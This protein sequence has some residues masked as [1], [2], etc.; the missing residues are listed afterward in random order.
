MMHDFMTVQVESIIQSALGIGDVGND[1]PPPALGN[2][3]KSIP[4]TAGSSTSAL[5][6]E[7]PHKVDPDIMNR[8]GARR[9]EKT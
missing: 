9:V 5:S 7:A 8:P 4:S 2:N 3:G 1:T 6:V